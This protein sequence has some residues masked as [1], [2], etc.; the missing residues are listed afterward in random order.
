MA[1]EA[2]QDIDMF[3]DV[4]SVFPGTPTTPESLYEV[5]ETLSRDDSCAQS[6]DS[7]RSVDQQ[8]ETALK[9]LVR[10]ELSTL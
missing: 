4:D 9:L 5:I 6:R 10:T 2:P 7:L 3:V 1:S 8:C